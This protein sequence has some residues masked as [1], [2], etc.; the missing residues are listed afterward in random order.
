M[1]EIIVTLKTSG[2]EE[3][4]TTVDTISEALKIQSAIVNMSDER[5]PYRSAT[6]RRRKWR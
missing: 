4:F 2:K 1:F 3:L 6:I 5:C